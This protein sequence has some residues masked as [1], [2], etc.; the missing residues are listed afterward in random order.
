[1]TIKELLLI[2]PKAEMSMLYLFM[3]DSAAP[4]RFNQYNPTNLRVMVMRMCKCL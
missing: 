4:Q 3:C 2:K 1:M